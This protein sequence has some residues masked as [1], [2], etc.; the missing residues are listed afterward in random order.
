MSGDPDEVST[1]GYG[2]PGNADKVP[3]GTHAMRDSS[4][5]WNDHAVSCR[6]DAVSAHGYIVPGED[7]L[8]PAE[9]D[10]VST[11]GD[12]VLDVWRRNCHSVPAGRNT[13]SNY[14]Q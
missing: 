13:M 7:N 5:R 9:G 12:A 4:R 6:D 1:A 10:G 3:T 2:V 8:L 11:G 14:R